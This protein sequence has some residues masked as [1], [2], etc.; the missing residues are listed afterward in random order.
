[1]T[2]AAG[3]D[4]VAAQP[5]P[6]ERTDYYASVL[7]EADFLGWFI[8]IQDAKTAGGITTVAVESYPLVR[9]RD[10]HPAHVCN[11]LNETWEVKGQTAKLVKTKAQ[12]EAYV[13]DGH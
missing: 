12:G 4:L 5:M 1:M 8:D 2:W 9:T 6:T 10:G 3:G 7:K 13:F 11:V